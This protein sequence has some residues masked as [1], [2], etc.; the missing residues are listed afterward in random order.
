MLSHMLILT[1]F[2]AISNEIASGACLQFDVI[3]FN[4]AARSTTHHHRYLSGSLLLCGACGATVF[5]Q[6][7]TRQPEGLSLFNYTRLRKKG[8]EATDS[9]IV[10]GE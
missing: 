10:V 3:D 5:S 6:P 9:C 2:T 7:K 8:V 4:N 1:F